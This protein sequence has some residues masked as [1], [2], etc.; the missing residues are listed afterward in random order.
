VLCM[1]EPE[2][3][4]HPGRVDVMVD[5]VRLLAVDPQESPGPENPLRQVIVNTHSPYFVQF[6]YADDLLLALPASVR[7]QEGICGTVRLAP[8]AGTWRART[9]PFTVTRASIVDYL[10]MPPGTQLQM[11]FGDPDNV[12]V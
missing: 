2:N 8:L 12:A 9:D 4:I 10:R 6:Q 5:L 11:H 1:E 3:G 7:R